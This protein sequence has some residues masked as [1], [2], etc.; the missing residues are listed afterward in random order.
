MKTARAVMIFPCIPVHGAARVEH[1]CAEK[2]NINNGTSG[3]VFWNMPDGARCGW[4][5]SHG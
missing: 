4:H 1:I 5:G 3:A 2:L